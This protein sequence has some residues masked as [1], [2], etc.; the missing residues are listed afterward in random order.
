MD[1]GFWNQKNPASLDPSDSGAGSEAFWNRKRLFST[2]EWLMMGWLH[3]IKGLMGCRLVGRC[4]EKCWVGGRRVRCG[5]SKN[6]QQGSKVSIAH[7]TA[8]LTEQTPLGGTEHKP[9]PSTSSFLPLSLCSCVKSCR[10]QSRNKRTL[11]LFQL[12]TS[13]LHM[14]VTKP[15][16]SLISASQKKQKE[17]KTSTETKSLKRK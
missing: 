12:N 15:R 11:R 13:R 16:K 6:T 4:R 8:L 1:P 2:R 5:G 7:R 14:F 9:G 10:I 17:R 3:E